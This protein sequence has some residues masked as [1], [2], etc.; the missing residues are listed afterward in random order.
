MRDVGE[1]SAGIG[2]P[3]V[4]GTAMAS[5]CWKENIYKNLRK[6]DNSL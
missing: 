6:M 1:D 3:K 5:G 4:V 2:I